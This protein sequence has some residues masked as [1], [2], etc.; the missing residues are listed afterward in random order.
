MSGALL[1]IV[2]FVKLEE[3]GNEVLIRASSQLEAGTSKNELLNI[4]TPC[5]LDEESATPQY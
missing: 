2:S 3:D 4:A 5:R 1:D